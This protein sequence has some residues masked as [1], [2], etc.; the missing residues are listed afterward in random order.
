MHT[1]QEAPPATGGSGW[2]AADLQRDT[3]WIVRIS[4]AD[5]TA[6]LA[7]LA[8]ASGKS[9]QL[10]EYRQDDFP[11][12]DSIEPVRRALAEAQHGR[13]AALL[14]GLPR[15]GVSEHDFRLL[16][17]GIGLHL[18]VARPQ[19]KAT[20]YLNE[21]RNAGGDYRSATGRGYSSNAELDFHVDGA[22]VVLLSCYNQAPRG[23]DSM[24]SSSLA[25]YRQ[26]RIER[27]DLAA[28]LHKALPFSLQGEQAEGRPAFIHMPVFGERDGR[29]FCMWV[30]NRVV[31]GEKLPGAPQLTERQR[32]AMDLLDEI[33]RRPAFMFSMRLEPG[34]LQI[35]SNHTVLHSRTEF[36]DS[37]ISEERRLLYR[38]WISTPD[39]P[40]LPPPWQ[41]YYGAVEVGTVRG[42]S[43]GQQYTNACRAFDEAQANAMGMHSP[44]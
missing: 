33:V 32:Q 39:A 11:F 2:L 38:L 37:P 13:G 16:T 35:L 26:M 4:D 10:L 29:I 21:V 9:K 19:D 44:D 6:M 36:E 20:R 31:F 43:F 23:G 30:R 7:A 27:P 1:A 41:A 12:G 42:G 8:S 22:D 24:C 28:E 15:E 17:W 14:K 5:R 3:S 34:D 25:A 40:Q 18:G